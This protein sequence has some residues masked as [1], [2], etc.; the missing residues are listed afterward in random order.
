MHI[1]EKVFFEESVEYIGTK[2]LVVK[3]QEEFNLKLQ[4]LKSLE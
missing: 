4:L 2:K 3:A 1:L